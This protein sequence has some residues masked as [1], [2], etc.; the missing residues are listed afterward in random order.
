[1][2]DVSNE[3]PICHHRSSLDPV[4]HSWRWTCSSR[5]LWQAP[6]YARYALKSVILVQQMPSQAQ[7]LDEQRNPCRMQQWQVKPRL[8]IKTPVVQRDPTSWSLEHSLFR[9]SST[10]SPA[11]EI[12]E[13]YPGQVS[14]V[15]N[16]GSDEEEKASS[17]FPKHRSA[18]P[19]CP[20]KRNALRVPRNLSIGEMVFILLDN[21]C[22]VAEV[23]S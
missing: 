12:Q 21:C 19:A 11:F 17:A 16:Q 23:S 4:V 15:A 14:L 3:G 6:Q 13:R 5:T 2:H 9:P 1:M 18:C 7:I 22:P 8:P 10:T 20:H